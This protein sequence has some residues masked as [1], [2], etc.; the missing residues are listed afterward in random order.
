MTNL[1]P[2]FSKAS[3]R[4]AGIDQSPTMLELQLCFKTSQRMI[5]HPK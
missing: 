2:R 1:N 5:S 3:T 4:Q